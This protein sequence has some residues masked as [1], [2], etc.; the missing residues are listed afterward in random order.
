M[1]D[2]NVAAGLIIHPTSYGGLSVRRT[3]RDTAKVHVG[4][5]CSFG[6]SVRVIVSGEHNTQWVTTYPFTDFE[7]WGAENTPGHPKPT[8]DVE[9]GNDVWVGDGALILGGTKIGDGAVIGARAVVAGV[10]Q[11]YSIMVGNPAR[12]AGS[13]F[14]PEFVDRLLKIRWWEWPQERIK[15]AVPMLLS[16]DIEAFC[17]AAEEGR[18]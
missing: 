4:A 15:T 2:P 11:P 6:D 7:G 16:P 18:V 13:R 9:I 10:V 5:F 3:N 8:G 17:L 12:R 1:T 14:A